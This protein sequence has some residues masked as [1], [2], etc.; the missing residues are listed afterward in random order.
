MNKQI[1]IL[2]EME[3][4]GYEYDYGEKPSPRETCTV[5]IVMKSRELSNMGQP[6]C[7]SCVR[8]DQLYRFSDPKGLGDGP[9]IALTNIIRAHQRGNSW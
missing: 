5:C 4:M 2:V 8:G 9:L 7:A 3:R 1:S 6:M